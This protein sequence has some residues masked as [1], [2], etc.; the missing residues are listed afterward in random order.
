MNGVLSMSMSMSMSRFAKGKFLLRVLV[1]A[2]LGVGFL[3]DEPLTA[4]SF[5]LYLTLVELLLIT[6]LEAQHKTIRLQ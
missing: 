6:E 5:A 2:T 4:V 3:I 1:W